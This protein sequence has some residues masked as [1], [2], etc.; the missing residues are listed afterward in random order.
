[1]QSC[2]LP[3]QLCTFSYKATRKIAIS[4]QALLGKA[5]DRS[6]MPWRTPSL[7]KECDRSHAL[8]FQMR[9]KILYFSVTISH[10]G[11]PK[12]KILNDLIVIIKLFTKDNPAGCNIK[13]GFHM[14]TT[15]GEAS[16]R[17]ARGHIGDDFVKWKH[18]LN[19][20][21]DVADQ[22]GTV[23][24]RIERVEMSLKAKFSYD[25][26]SDRFHMSPTDR[27][28]VADVSQ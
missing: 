13:P 12:S 6:R 28:H 8:S 17:Q 20:V 18:F 25:H 10:S 22:T 7:S 9:I 4:L 15:V 2:E 27:G 26:S 23:R 3:R 24:G 5:C 21:A 14:I 1:M 16:P 11:S 19:D